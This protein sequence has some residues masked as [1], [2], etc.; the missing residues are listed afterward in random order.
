M[1]R[2]PTE[3]PVYR[4]R[5]ELLAHHVHAMRYDRVI[6]FYTQSVVELRDQAEGDRARGRIQTAAALEKA[7]LKLEEFIEEMNK[8]WCICKPHMKEEMEG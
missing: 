7:A 3:V 2:H 4:D 8:V 6:A 1:K 5:L